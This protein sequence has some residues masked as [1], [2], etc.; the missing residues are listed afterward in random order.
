MSEEQ[1]KAKAAPEAEKPA[2]KPHVVKEAHPH[3]KKVTKMNLAEVEEAIA[4]CQKQQGGL[5]SRYGQSLAGHKAA[6]MA[7]HAPVRLKKAA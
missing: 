3:A 7:M 1:K 5:W 6:L 2:P 4:L